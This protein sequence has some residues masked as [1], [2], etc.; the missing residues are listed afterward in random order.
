MGGEKTSW[1]ADTLMSDFARRPL[2]RGLSICAIAVAVSALAAA[3]A[4]AKAGDPDPGFDGDGR[5]VIK[6]AKETTRGNFEI[7]RLPSISM[8]SAAGP[9]GEL[10]AANRRRV[11]RYRASGRP[12]EHFGGDGRVAIPTPAGTSFQLAGVVVDSGGRVLVAG[13]TEPM[14]AGGG[15]LDA[16]VSVYRFMPDGKIDRS[17]GVHGVAGA[18][19]GPMEATGIALDSLNRPVLTGFTALTPFACG[20][21]S[22][23]R[24]TTTVARLTTSGSPDRTFAGGDGIFTDPLEDPH[25]PTL[26]AGGQVVY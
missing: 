26:T 4:L 10:V 20:L 23:Y 25:L 21:T 2:R 18:S 14:G 5:L 19:L 17:F 7:T 24:N 15:S 11:F 12:R 1:T 8:A 6:A 9:K 13:T 22:I 3:G 16:R